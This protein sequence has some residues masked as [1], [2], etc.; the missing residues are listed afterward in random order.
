MSK[1]RQLSPWPGSSPV[2]QYVWYASF[3]SNLHLARL[4][5][6]LAGGRPPGT[7]RT[8]PGARDPA[9]P[10]AS[11]AVTLPGEVYFAGESPVWT[12]GVAFYDPDATGDAAARAHLV[13][14]GQFADI[15]AQEGD[16]PPGVDLDLAPVVAAGRVRRGPGPYETLVCAGELAGRP[17]F[18]C[19]GPWRSTEVAHTAPAA[20]YLRHLA[21]GL[22]ESHGWAAERIAA[23]LA[24]RPGVA[25]RWAHED[26]LA[27]AD[28]ELASVPRQATAA[29]EPTRVS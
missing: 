10:W 2:P 19:T 7:S 25:G 24:A 29:T 3:G 8:Y 13:S 14:V 23:Y 1:P 26:L 11:V 18:T 6:Y 20:G 12:G 4:R 28:G 27:V 15:V 9:D 21:V 17:V 5:Y 16:R 22:R